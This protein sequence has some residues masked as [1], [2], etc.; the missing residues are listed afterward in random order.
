MN[1]NPEYYKLIKS[2]AARVS[3]RS[4]FK[5]NKM[6]KIEKKVN[7]FL[8]TLGVNYQYS[9]KLGGNQYDFGIKEKTI[10]IE[11]DGDYWHGNPEFY[12]VDG[13][14]GKRILNNI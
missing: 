2:N 4:Q 14:D 13:S 6:N 8:E 9:I 3:H 11:I 7:D 10:L 1:E 5:K 12:N